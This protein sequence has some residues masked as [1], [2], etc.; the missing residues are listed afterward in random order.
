MLINVYVHSTGMKTILTN[1]LRL[2]H[3]TD[4]AV[5]GVARDSRGCLIEI[6]QKRATLLLMPFVQRKFE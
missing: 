1:R 3:A 2:Q 6:G 5:T 4:H